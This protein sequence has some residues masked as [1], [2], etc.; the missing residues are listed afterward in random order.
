MLPSSHQPAAAASRLPND[1]STDQTDVPAQVVSQPS[2][3]PQPQPQVQA[4]PDGSPALSG[5]AQRSSASIQAVAVSGPPTYVPASAEVVNADPGPA[6]DAFRLIDT[7]SALSPTGAAANPGGTSSATT[8]SSTVAAVPSALANADDPDAELT[9]WK[10]VARGKLQRVRALLALPETNVNRT[11]YRGAPS[12]LIKAAAKGHASIVAALLAAG[13][14]VNYEDRWGYTA[15]TYAV[16]HG[17]V[18]TIEALLAGGADVNGPSGPPP[19][20]STGITPLIVASGSGTNIVRLLLEHEHIDVNRV[21]R[22]GQSALFHAAS[23]GDKAVVAQLIKAGSVLNNREYQWGATALMFAV[24]RSHISVVE[25]LAAQ[26]GIELDKMDFG[27]CTALMEAVRSNRTDKAAL[28]I[29]L[30]ASVTLVNPLNGRNAFL[31]AVVFGHAAVVGFLLGQPGIEIDKVTEYGDVALH[32]AVREDRAA[33]VEVLLQHGTQLVDS[34]SLP[35]A[36]TA[37]SIAIADLMSEHK[38]TAANW[39]APDRLV[40]YFDQLAAIISHTDKT[41]DVLLC[42][43]DKGISMSVAW[44]LVELLASACGSW[45]GSSAATS[46]TPRQRRMF[47]VCA[48]SMLHRPDTDKKM[49]ADYT[50]SEI[51]PA[52]VDRLSAKA[53]QELQ[54]LAS[55]A[56]R[57]AAEIGTGMLD[58]LVPACLAWTGPGVQ[59]AA[60]TLRETLIEESFCAPL[61]QAIASAWCEAIATV[62]ARILV[63]P[64]GLTMAQVMQLVQDQKASDAPREFALAL[65]RQLASRDS[66]IMLQTMLGGTGDEGLHALF[67]VQCDQLLQFCEQLLDS[68]T[69]TATTANT[70]STSSTS[71]LPRQ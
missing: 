34:I 15:L 44:Q 66:L 69:N 3:Q 10:A 29:R 21:D 70:S 1:A 30:G 54:T 14:S 45:S 12:L 35:M 51:S 64:V 18:T 46:A 8:S 33:I 63:I 71:G 5:M 36:R 53:A 48:L 24:Q 26:P 67:Q 55:M 57:A 47:F 52:A 42:L 41:P 40:A 58:K 27:G 22:N 68:P 62:A 59:V 11:D 37:S 65:R 13:A 50:A 6:S 16:A 20:E 19:R 2:G 49:V 23:G 4:R 43:H 60:D 31:D 25:E 17:D 38:G 9:L 39:P 32:L 28:L 61:A 56:A 7:P